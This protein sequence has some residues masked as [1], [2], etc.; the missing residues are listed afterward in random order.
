MY[1]VTQPEH[2]RTKCGMHVNKNAL[3]TW[4]QLIS[5]VSRLSKSQNNP[6]DLS[7]NHLNVLQPLP[8]KAL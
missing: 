4:P 5:A 6:K 1:I 8:N 3:D 7:I 2:R